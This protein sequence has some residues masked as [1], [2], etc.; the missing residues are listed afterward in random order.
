M[1][2]FEKVSFE[3]S[4]TI[5]DSL[6]FKLKKGEVFGI[7]GSSGVGKTTLLAL[8]CGLEDPSQGKVFFENRPL[9]GPSQRLIP[10]H[11][12]IQLV[13]QEFDLDLYHTVKENI[14]MKMSHLPMDVRASFT[15]EL[16]ELMELQKCENQQAKTLSGGEK[17]R[18]AI[19]RALA[20]EPK[21]VV[22]DEP[23]SHLDGPIKRKLVSYIAQLKK[24]RKTTFVLV[25]HDGEDML[26]LADRI[27][28][29]A[30]A[31][32]QRIATPKEFYEQPNSFEEGLLFGDL[33]QVKINKNIRWF[34]PNNY[35]LLPESEYMNS[36]KVSYLN[37]SFSGFYIK[38]YFRVNKNSSI[39]LYHSTVLNH[40]K[41]IFIS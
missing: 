33:N 8:L 15:N 41:E 21:M 18:L 16:V 4:R 34:R 5:L 9:L 14:S 32:I 6:S 29:L 1:I 30:A 12:D 25:S 23:F 37:S 2:R 39:V 35:R 38:N 28:Y 19:A 17:Q 11:P 27:L 20:L 10:G 31:K 13:N 3:R 24:I 40:V 26:S 7:V 36:L 22:L